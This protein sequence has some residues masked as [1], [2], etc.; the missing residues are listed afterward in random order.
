M[1]PLI[2][3]LAFVPFTVARAQEELNE[4]ER[5]LLT[6]I[7]PLQRAV[8]RDDRAAVAQLLVYPLDVW[9]GRRRVTVNS[10]SEFLAIYDQVVD[11]R[12]KR[13][14]A[15]ADVRKAFSNSQ[16]FMFDSGRIWIGMRGDAFGVVTIN[17]PTIHRFGE[18]ILFDDESTMSFAGVIGE[19]AGRG[20]DGAERFLFTAPG[21]DAHVSIAPDQKEA[22]FTIDRR[23][24]TAELVAPATEG[25][26]GRLILWTTQAH[27]RLAK[28]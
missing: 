17:D 6:V 5:T 7:E 1:L 22:T 4:N 9:N 13:T 20:D 11:F 16:G 2:A 14:I 25:R 21:G 27:R 3:L 26:S 8:E 19:Y 10:P 28:K 18:S 15:R 24:Y 12:L 23:R